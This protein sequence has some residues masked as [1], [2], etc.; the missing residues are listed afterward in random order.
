MTGAAEQAP[1]PHFDDTRKA[2]EFALNF[3]GDT[4]APV[5]SRV[6]AQVAAAPRRVSKAARRRLLRQYEDPELAAFVSAVLDGELRRRRMR[7]GHAP[8]PRGLD[9]AHL[10]GWILAHF[11]RLD[12]HHQT[13]LTGRCAVA[14]DRCACGSPCCSG[15]RKQARWWQ[16]VRD[17]CLHLELAGEVTRDGKRGLSTQPEMRVAIVEQYYTRNDLSLVDMARIGGVTTVTAAKH[18]AWVYEY[19]QQEE[20]AAWE[21][22][23]AIFDAAGIVGAAP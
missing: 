7:G 12:P 1:A 20:G 4:K 18:R 19:L 13:I 15:W 3:R 22:L 14:Y 8:P 2:L 17:T 10:A 9:G 21:Q 16:A 5:M 6:M 23:D 11:A